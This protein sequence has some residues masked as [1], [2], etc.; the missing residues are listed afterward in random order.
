MTI[1]DLP[2]LPVSRLAGEVGADV[3]VCGFVETVR[4]QKAMQFVVLRDRTGY[5]QLVHRREDDPE[6]AERLDGLTTES[7][8][9]AAGTVVADDRV[10]LGGLELRLTDLVVVG[11]AQA[12]LPIDEQ[13]S[14]D[15]RLDYPWL[16]WRPPDRQLILH[17]QTSLLHAMRSFWVQRGMV[18][19]HSPKLM[20]APSESGAEVFALEYFS[21]RA[22]LAQSPQFYKQL[23]MAA[24][25]DGVFEV[26]PVFRAEP[27]HT[28]RH[29]T[30]FTSIDVELAWVDSHEDVMRHEE[31]LLTEAIS[32]VVE[33]YG[34]RLQTAFGVQLD[35]PSTPFPRI[36]VGSARELLLTHTDWRPTATDD[37]TLDPPG[38]R[39]LAQLIRETEDHDF[40]FVTDYPSS[41]RPFYHRRHDD[42]PEL[43]RSFDLLFRG[44]EITTG[45]QREHRYEPLTE[46]AAAARLD[47]G[48]LSTYLDSFKHGCPPHGGF[49]L[50]LERLTMA[51]LSLP[52]I[53]DA[54]FLPRTPTRLTP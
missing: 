11:A 33:R 5:V 26:G 30:E 35:V 32:V 15:L 21:R 1:D 51:M 4:L 13:S 23:A 14:P 44:L 22:Y 7:A 43:T 9:I 52:S 2:R 27:S 46:Q 48:L 50:G 16:A 17:I 31:R 42:D 47:L 20:G 18:E 37:G 25:I 39:A 12:P 6:L 54:T 36:S 45:A 53:R 40:V 24:G 8:V 41:A 19:L 29:V 34:Q 3:A 49:G 10:K 28:S 38:E